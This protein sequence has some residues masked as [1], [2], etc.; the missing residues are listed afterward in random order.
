MLR[1]KK[2]RLFELRILRGIALLLV[3]A[4]IVGIMLAI[5]RAD[6]RILIASAGIGGLAVIYVFAVKRGR[7]L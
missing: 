3:V 1:K 4:A 6:W 7:P 5:H 2:F